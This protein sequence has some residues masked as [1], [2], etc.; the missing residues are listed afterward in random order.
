MAASEESKQGFDWTTTV[1]IVIIVVPVF[2]AISAVGWKLR[3]ILQARKQRQDDIEMNNRRRQWWQ[4]GY[5]QEVAAA[6]GSRS[7]LQDGG[8][9]GTTREQAAVDMFRQR[10]Y[11]GRPAERKPQEPAPVHTRPESPLEEQEINFSRPMSRPMPRSKP[12]LR[13]NT[14][15]LPTA[16][17][18][19]ESPAATGI[20]ESFIEDADFEGYLSEDALEQI[21]PRRT[22]K[23]YD[24]NLLNQ[25]N[26][27]LKT[28]EGIK[29]FKFPGDDADETEKQTLFD[30]ILQHKAR[31]AARKAARE[32]KSGGSR[33]RRS[34]RTRRGDDG[35]EHAQRRNRSGSASNRRSPKEKEKSIR[36]LVGALFSGETNRR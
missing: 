36:K 10:L 12:D 22:V 27:A 18:L 28:E 24:R 19:E 8:V 7:T 6:E 21:L 1:Y 3:R 31:K 15:G 35:A 14:T 5:L 17:V 25:A 26:E 4:P 2:F 23:H 29:N 16:T 20:E 32:A 11:G 33:K 34:D 30:A 9:E 13:I